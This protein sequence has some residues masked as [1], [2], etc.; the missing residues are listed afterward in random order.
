[1]L[2]AIGATLET[3]TTLDQLDPPVLEPTSEYQDYA[4]EIPLGD[5]GTRG[6]GFPIAR[7]AFALMTAVEQRAALRDFCPA[8]SAA[9]YITTRKNDGSYADFSAIM[10]WPLREQRFSD[11]EPMD[12]VIEFTRL[13]EIAGS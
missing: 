13:V 12:L 6:V 1:M 10:H 4:E 5:T 8:K 11:D 7:W 2:Y 3:L 9:V